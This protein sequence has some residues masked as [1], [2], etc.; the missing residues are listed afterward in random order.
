MTFNNR[1]FEQKAVEAVGKPA[2]AIQKS[3][4]S[5][6]KELYLMDDEDMSTDAEYLAWC[7][8]LEELS[9]ELK[10]DYHGYISNLKYLKWLE[11]SVPGGSFDCMVLEHNKNLEHLGLFGN[12]YGEIYVENLYRLQSCKK[13]SE[14]F[15]FEVR[16]LDIHGIGSIENLD[17]LTI[18][19][20]NDIIKNIDELTNISKL[21]YLDLCD[22]RVESL[23]FLRGLDEN[24][25]LVLIEIDSEKPIDMKSIQR[26][27][28]REVDE[29]IPIWKRLL[30]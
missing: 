23:E 18:E 27:K 22:V 10:K 5:V 13:L 14:L 28:N 16:D 12:T 11:L 30:K 8:N 4:L 6:L 21:K 9:V 26:F 1:E 19:F 15:L 17:N 25:F 2:D 20:S 29:M 3:D 24:V 7:T